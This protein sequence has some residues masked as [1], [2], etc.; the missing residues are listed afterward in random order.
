MSEL[1]EKHA[2]VVVL[3]SGQTCYW[4]PTFGG[5]VC[6]SAKG[7]FLAG[8]VWMTRDHPAWR[9]MGGTADPDVFPTLEE[10]ILAALRDS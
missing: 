8:G 2:V 7:Y 4:R 9:W 6:E 3:K 5:W 1:I 10:A